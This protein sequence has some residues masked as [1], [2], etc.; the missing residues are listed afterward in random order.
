METV[1]KTAA[2]RITKENV[3]LVLKSMSRNQ[4]QRKLKRCYRVLR[5]DVY[6]AYNWRGVIGEM[7]KCSKISE[8]TIMRKIYGGKERKS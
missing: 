8:R 6:P 7:T 3:F 2:E 5:K 1:K 4:I